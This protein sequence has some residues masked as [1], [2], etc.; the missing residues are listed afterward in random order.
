MQYPWRC[1]SCDSCNRT[2][3]LLWPA[4]EEGPFAIRFIFVVSLQSLGP[5]GKAPVG[6]WKLPTPL[7]RTVRGFSLSRARPGHTPA[8]K[9]E[10]FASDHRTKPLPPGY[11][12]STTSLPGGLAPCTHPA[13]H[14]P[15][16]RVSGT[17]PGAPAANPPGWGPPPQAR[18]ALGPVRITPH[19]RA[20]PPR[21]PVVAAG[22]CRPTSRPPWP[23][24]ASAAGAGA[25]AP[26][27]MSIIL[28]LCRRQTAPRSPVHTV[29]SLRRPDRFCLTRR[30]CWRGIPAAASPLGVCGGLSYYFRAAGPPTV[31]RPRAWVPRWRPR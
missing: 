19:P 14:A 1:P 26:P 27:R 17:G 20:A 3:C 24:Q 25:E 12:P 15:S 10:Q 29:P 8:A 13:G 28:T 21:G 16:G 9:G 30:R 11:N 31:G 23:A 7:S 18:A 22:L 4:P 2:E 5:A 6:I